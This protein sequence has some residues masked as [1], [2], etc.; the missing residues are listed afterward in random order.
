MPFKKTIFCP[1]SIFSIQGQPVLF[2]LVKNGELKIGM[3][4]EIDKKK[5][6][7]SKIELGQGHLGITLTGL[8]TTQAQNL[9]NK[10]L[11]FE[12]VI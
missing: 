5:L 1:L 3:M 7:I 6:K 2:G 11:E 10:E 9:L 12:K 4:T 8:D